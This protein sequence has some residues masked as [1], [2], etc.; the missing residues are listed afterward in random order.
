[1]ESL[2]FSPDCMD[3]TTAMSIE[4]ELALPTPPSVV[5]ETIPPEPLQQTTTSIVHRRYIRCSTVEYESTLP[6]NAPLKIDIDS[7]TLMEQILLLGLNDKQVNIIQKLM[8]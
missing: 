5:I 8:D 7:L 3:T 6:P 2:K 1:M 4:E